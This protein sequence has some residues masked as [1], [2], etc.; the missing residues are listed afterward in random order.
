MPSFP[1]SSPI[2]SDDTLT[3][4]LC[5]AVAA[6]RSEH[7]TLTLVLPES[8][9]LQPAFF[10][11]LAASWQELRDKISLGTNVVLR[12]D[13]CGDESRLGMLRGCG[14]RLQQWRSER[15]I[16]RRNLREVISLSRCLVVG[17]PSREP[18]AI[19]MGIADPS[20]SL[21]EWVKPAEISM[22]YYSMRA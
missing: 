6:N 20:V 15:A 10:C 8:I 5:H 22:P 11:D 21:P 1:P 7:K 17:R 13:C 16:D 2:H 19:V 9:A 18:S 3:T 12:V 14:Q 4:F